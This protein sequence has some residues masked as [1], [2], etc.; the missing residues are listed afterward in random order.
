MKLLLINPPETRMIRADNPEFI[1]EERGANP[2]LG[3]L[4][5]AAAARK[6]PNWDVQVIDCVGEGL[7]YDGLR[8]RVRTS[9]AQ[10]V[11][12][13]VLTFTV[14]DVLETIRVVREE[15]PESRI[16]L[17]GP[18]AH[19]YPVETLGWD[20]VDMVAMGE[21]E[22][23]IHGLLEAFP[24]PQAMASIRGLVFSNSSGE[25][26][27][28]GQPGFI[29]DLD[30][31]AYPAR[32]AT[33]IGR[34]S[35]VVSEHNPITT[36][37]TS[38]GCPFKCRYCDRPHLG[39]RFR[40][41]SAGY[42]LEEMRQCAEMGIREIF[43]YD[44]T[45]TV[46][47]SR[48]LEI[49]ERKI[50]EGIDLPFDIRTRVDTVDPEM[51]DALKAAGCARIHYGV[52]A[53][54]EK[55]QKVLGKG[56]TLEQAQKAFRMTKTAGIKSLAYFM[57]GSPTETREDIRRSMRF[58]LTLDPDFVSITVLT[59]FPETDIYFRAL[60]EGVI[61][62]DYFRRFAE[63]PFDGFRVKYWERELDREGL[64][65]ELERAYRMFY[66]RPKFI[67]RETLKVRSLEELKKK[68]KMGLKVLG[69]VKS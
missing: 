2:P 28:G 31:L 39:R 34:Y 14:Y 17:G 21:G 3:I 4:Y 8:E 50:R 42:V 19:I 65:E 35:S 5:V 59:P 11:G 25:T 38:R 64:F 48:V 7:D 18:H 67:L 61:G 6:N 55:I 68:A 15:T 58:A 53:G 44:D 12:I 1:D 43:V 41:H 30:A 16:I 40:A 47:R 45:F 37:I 63:K 51:L 13:T 10:L 20:G 49:C 9:Q 56:I 29:P 22:P 26:L 69:L 60:E 52:E 36:M 46:N 33:N 66:G 57:I 24:D 32:D 54:T 62:D 23:V 27:H